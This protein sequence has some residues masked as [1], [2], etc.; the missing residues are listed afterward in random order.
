MCS[1]DPT[2]R[3]GRLQRPP[4]EHLAPRNDARRVVPLHGRRHHP[5]DLRLAHTVD[6]QQMLKPRQSRCQDSA[7]RP[8]VLVHA[9]RG[10]DL[11][12]TVRGAVQDVE[13]HRRD[14]GLLLVARRWRVSCHDEGLR[15]RGRLVDDPRV[16]LHTQEARGRRGCDGTHPVIVAR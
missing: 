8:A 11:E 9:L 16:T 14:A 2:R 1:A 12:L 10:H 6:R 7:P 3:E 13:G 15:R 4:L 5:E